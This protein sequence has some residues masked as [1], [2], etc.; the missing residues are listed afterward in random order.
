MS[1][2]E[3]R[4]IVR[5]ACDILERDVLYRVTEAARVAHSERNTLRVSLGSSSRR[6]LAQTLNELSIVSDDLESCRDRLLLL[7]G[8]LRRYEN[9]I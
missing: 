6:D 1:I 2:G 7:I 5:N 9:S 3:A 8:E 4:N